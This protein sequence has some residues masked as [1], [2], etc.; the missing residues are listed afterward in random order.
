MSGEADLVKLLEDLKP[1]LV[2]NPYV[3]AILDDDQAHLLPV[4]R[5]F[6]IVYE[7]RGITAVCEQR[8][9]RDYDLEHSGPFACIHLSVQSSLHAVG[10]TACV[11]QALADAQISANLIAGFD[12]DHI[13]VPYDRR[14]DAM[15]I[16]RSLSSK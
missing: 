13:F 15:S 5:P 8:Q 9:I 1:E 6:A 12:H 7:E 4:L 16:L 3:F 2:S 14:H 10:L 11:S